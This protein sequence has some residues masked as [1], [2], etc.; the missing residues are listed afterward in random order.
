VFWN[1][2]GEPIAIAALVMFWAFWRFL[3]IDEGPPGLPFSCS[4]HLFQ[5]VV[6]VFYFGVT[7]RKLEPML[8]L[9]HQHMMWLATA[10]I[11]A[12]AIGF[13][14]GNHWTKGSKAPPERLR[15]NVSIAQMIGGYII[16]VLAYD[17]VFQFAYKIPLFTQAI[18]ALLTIQ[19]GLLYLL[20]RR[21]FREGRPLVAVA[22]VT[23]EIARGFTGFYSEFKEP[24]LLALLAAAEVFR[25]RRTSHWLLVA[26]LMVAAVMLGTVWLGI[27]SQIRADIAGGS[28]RPRTERLA[29]AIDEARVWWNSDANVKI[30]DLDDLVERVWDIYYSALALDRVPSQIPYQNGAIAFAAIQHVFMP[31]FL[32][33][34]K[35]DL[36]SESDD[37][38]RYTGMRVAGRA[39]GTTIAFGSVIQSYIDFGVPLMFVPP[40]LLGV[41]LG[42]TYRWLL[43]TVHYEEILLAIVAVAFWSTLMTYNVSWAKILGKFLTT[44]V[45]MGGPGVIIDKVLFESRVRHGAM[46]THE[47]EPVHSR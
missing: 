25:P 1:L 10:S 34:D 18:L 16:V 36:P 40:L 47:Q 44:L 33:P 23:I 42:V 3:P 15:L 12:I 39:Q 2:S 26:T 46:V 19:G 32:Y 22:I 8:A 21:L 27:R 20:I 5:I 30:Y 24:V 35:A 37:V 31:R 17:T 7:Q 45:Y 29:F 13:V 43:K 4:F 14:A 28:E 38:Y 41:L 9:Q 6:G 11:G